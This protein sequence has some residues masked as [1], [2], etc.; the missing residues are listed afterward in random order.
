MAA[1]EIQSEDDNYSDTMTE[2]EE[3]DYFD[4]LPPALL[5]RRNDR[6]SRN[7]VSAEAFGRFNQ[8]TEFKPPVRNSPKI[9]FFNFSRNVGL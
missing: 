7:S 5:N 9:Y 4:E 8:K 1:S 2:S 6:K 3:E